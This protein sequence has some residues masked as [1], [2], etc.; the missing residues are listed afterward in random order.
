MKHTKGQWL[1]GSGNISTACVIVKQYN[2][3]DAYYTNVLNADEREANAKL[4]AAA[5]EMLECLLKLT[6]DEHIEPHTYNHFIE[7]AKQL[8]NK[9]I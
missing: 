8:I 7:Q 4:I 5:P 1:I 9:I 2:G 6:T 3:N